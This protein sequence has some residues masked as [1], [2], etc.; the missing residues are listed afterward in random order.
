MIYERKDVIYQT[1]FDFDSA[2]IYTDKVSPEYQRIYDVDYWS[3]DTLMF[4]AT[5]DG[6][7]DL[8]LYIPSTRESIR[9]TD[10]FYDDLD[11]SVV[12]INDQRYVLF[13]PI[14]LTRHYGKWNW[15]PYP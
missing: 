6:L 12:H 4:A 3:N 8:Y 2:K 1:T 10:D 11:A 15:I 7:A 5:T 9:M 14:D 13:R